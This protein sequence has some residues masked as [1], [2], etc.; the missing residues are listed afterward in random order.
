M[1]DKRMVFATVEQAS[2]DIVAGSQQLQSTLSQ[3]QTDLSPIA[4]DTANWDADSGE[5]YRGYQQQW[6]EAATELFEVLRIIGN[7]V[8]TAHDNGVATETANTS[9]WAV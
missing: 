8:Q 9:M 2:S 6:D 3:L 4:R 5:A 7:G 1:A